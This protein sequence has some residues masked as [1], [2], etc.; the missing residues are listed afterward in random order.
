MRLL[1]SRAAAQRPAPF[2]RALLAAPPNGRRLLTSAHL[3]WRAVARTGREA[4]GL[5]A[6]GSSPERH[7]HVRPCVSAARAGRKLV[8]RR[9]GRCCA[10]GAGG[11]A[12]WRGAGVRRAEP[13]SGR[14]CPDA[15]ACGLGPLCAAE[16]HAPG[17]LS[18]VC[19]VREVSFTMY[20]INY[21]CVY[22]CGTHIYTE[23]SAQHNSTNCMYHI[24]YTKS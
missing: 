7:A 3:L 1:P 10:G 5:S 8:K 22:T 14:L 6:H 11:C 23:R 2:A 12:G 17:I 15:L 16:R 24:Y 4:V 21:R 9:P 19:T 20:S 18:V 13:S